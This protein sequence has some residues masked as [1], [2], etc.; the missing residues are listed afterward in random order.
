MRRLLLA[1]MTVGAVQSAQAADMPDLPFLRGGISAASPRANWSGAYVG[2]QVSYG[3]ADMDF[4]QATQDLMERLLNH[5]AFE[6]NTSTSNDPASDTRVSRWR[7]LGETTMQNSG[8]GGFVGYNFQMDD[9]IFGVELNYTHGKFSGSALG[10]KGRFDNTTVP[11]YT[12]LLSAS[13]SSSMEVTDFGSLRVRAGYALGGF[14]PYAFGGVA[15]GQANIARSIN[16]NIS[17]LPAKIPP[18]VPPIPDFNGSLSDNANSHFIYG[19]SWGLGFD[20]MLFAN[21]FIRGEW[22]YLR[23]TAAVDTTI[24]TVRAGVGYK[25]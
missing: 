12:T 3:S 1:A 8:I 24:N 18:T 17:Y 20:Y 2:G 9:T 7:M 5:T 6:N 14:L 25:F 16:V 21:I 22:E 13:A 19:Y 4:G 15:L 23:F 11:D 10:S